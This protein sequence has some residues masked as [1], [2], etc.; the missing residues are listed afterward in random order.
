MTD[1]IS[2]AV[3]GSITSQVAK[4]TAEWLKNRGPEISENEWMIVG[5]QIGNELLAI[6]TQFEQSPTALS[7]LEREVKSAWR[8]YEK[9]AQVGEDFE[10]DEIF[11]EHY[12][13]MS[14]G[15]GEW[16]EALEMNDKERLYGDQFTDAYNDYKSVALPHMK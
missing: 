16:S 1:P 12:R 8:T 14:E 4:G 5:Y 15:C 3:V 7:R 6:K 13:E 11:I 9:L 10:F 2:A